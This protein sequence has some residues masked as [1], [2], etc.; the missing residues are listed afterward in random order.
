M[1]FSRE[2][3]TLYAVT[4]RKWAGDDGLARDV[5]RA[6]KGGATMV[7]L[8]EKCMGEEKFLAEAK[9]MAYL[10][11][12]LGIPLIIN[13]SVRVA[14]LSGADG[15]H[16]GQSDGDPA[17]IRRLAGGGFIIGVTARTVMEATA[18]EAA[19]A[20]YI[21]VGAAFPTTTKTD[22]RHLTREDF[23]AITSAVNIPAVAIGGITEEN[24]ACLSGTGV[25][26][27]A[28]VSAIFSADDVEAAARRLRARAEEV[29]A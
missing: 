7:Q 10:C 2:M 1:I 17:E 27:I 6:I 22:T 9:R 24:A 15:V 5:E 11:H 3:L 4:D 25:A 23:S 21:G 26:G 16:I 28:V 20:D 14:I 8:R 19:G 12:S 13:D 29:V 18:A